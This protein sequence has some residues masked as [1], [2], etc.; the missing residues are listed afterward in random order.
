MKS[1]EKNKEIDLF[2]KI[3][4]YKKV[5]VVNGNLSGF[6]FKFNILEDCYAIQVTEDTK[7]VKNVFDSDMKS[8]IQELNVGS[9]IYMSKESNIQLMEYE[10]K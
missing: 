9:N 8:T 5:V 4:E 7:K 3:F 10:E 6:V 2:Y 1:Q